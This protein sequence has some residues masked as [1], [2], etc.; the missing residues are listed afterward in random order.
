MSDFTQ[1]YGNAAGTNP[2]GSKA[3]D[4]LKN[5]TGKNPDNTQGQQKTVDNNQ[6][7]SYIPD[8]EPN[9]DSQGDEAEVQRYRNLLDSNFQGD[10][11]KAIKSYV[12]IQAKATKD[13][14]R[15]KELE[16]QLNYIGQLVEKEPKLQDL[17]DR[18]ANG[19]SLENLFGD[20][21]PAQGQSSTPTNKGQFNTSTDEIT[22]RELVQAGLLDESKKATMSEYEWDREVLRQTQKYLKTYFEQ[23]ASQV[24]RQTFEEEQR[25]LNET[26]RIQFIK[27]ENERRYTEGLKRAAMMGFDFNGEHS[28]LLD[29]IDEEIL[30]FRDRQDPNLF[31]PDAFDVALRIVSERNGIMSKATT[32]TQQRSVRD[33]QFDRNIN[34]RG[35]QRKTEPSDFMEA[36]LTKKR[37]Q[38]RSKSGDYMKAFNKD[39]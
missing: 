2:D 34:T 36:L 37:D 27:T 22:E 38:Y 26:R 18:V 11:I 19:E 32:T 39:R 6:N 21:N 16:K 12:N 24:A 30:T 9:G 28:S 15:A 29:E 31:R 20:K 3:K 23:K 14:Q 1:T 4:F 13:S 7:N 10:P 25:K 33:L 8:N 35:E 5:L 17:L